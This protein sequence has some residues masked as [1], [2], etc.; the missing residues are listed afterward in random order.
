MLKN[1]DKNAILR[2]HSLNQLCNDISLLKKKKRRKVSHQTT[3][4]LYSREEEKLVIRL[5]KEKS[6]N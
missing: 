2:Q 3:D 6:Q 1:F 5:Y 4:Y